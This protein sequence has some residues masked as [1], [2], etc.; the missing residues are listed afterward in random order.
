MR[1]LDNLWND[2]IVEAENIDRR[3]HEANL[4]SRIFPFLPQPLPQ[5][6]D[7]Y[8]LAEPGS[9]DRRF[10][11]HLDTLEGVAPRL[12]LA[13]ACHRLV[14]HLYHPLV[15]AEK[16]HERPV[17][18]TATEDMKLKTALDPINSVSVTVNVSS[19]RDTPVSQTPVPIAPPLRP[20]FNQR[21]RDAFGY[22]TARTIRLD[23]KISPV[24][25]PLVVHPPDLF[26]WAREKHSGSGVQDDH[27][28][29]RLNMDSNP[30]VQG[31]M[32][33]TKADETTMELSKVKED[34]RAALQEI[35]ELHSL[36]G[37][38]RA[39]NEQS[40]NDLRVLRAL[41][42]EFNNRIHEIDPETSD[43]SD[44]D[45]D[46]EDTNAGTDDTADKEMD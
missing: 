19:P 26:I 37:V 7:V 11:A 6:L 10:R 27:L 43:I 17:V 9:D 12:P 44:G 20:Y 28:S 41:V 2:W 8:H 46:V 45:G 23:R 25:M 38:L 40:Q 4:T 13:I 5:G 3:I 22:P 21:S 15:Y 14:S 30:G 29:K 36:I 42:D 18:C 39:T 31:G 35:G 34:L 32:E 16:N 33:V 1:E 24:V